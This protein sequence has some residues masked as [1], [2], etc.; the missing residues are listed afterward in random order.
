MSDTI[1]NHTAIQS[2]EIDPFI[3][4]SSSVLSEFSEKPRTAILYGLIH[5]LSSNGPCFASNVYLAQR[6][7]VT[8]RQVQNMIKE[9]VAEGFVH[10]K[11]T[12]GGKRYLSPILSR[13]SV[14]PTSPCTTVH[15]PT[16]HSSPPPRSTVHPYNKEEKKAYKKESAPLPDILPSSTKTE[17]QTIADYLLGEPPEDD[18]LLASGFKPMKEFPEL[19][20]RPH[21]LAKTCEMLSKQ[22]ISLDDAKVCF[23]IINAKMSGLD[24]RDAKK[25]RT[26]A[27]SYVVSFGLEQTLKIL[28]EQTKLKV[29]KNR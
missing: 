15:P 9:L 10:R 23:E 1:S 16:K 24:P 2:K 8:S 13:A 11:V 6:L 5:G 29:N 18:P 28:N 17:F 4:I 21:E 27:Y 7:A 12:P 19:W 22:G 26:K 25:R 3:I 14:S 20:F